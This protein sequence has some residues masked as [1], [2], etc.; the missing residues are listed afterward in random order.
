VCSE[1]NDEFVVTVLLLFLWMPNF[2]CVS[3]TLDRNGDD[4]PDRRP[5]AY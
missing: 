1:W 3:T 2:E 4:I 5:C